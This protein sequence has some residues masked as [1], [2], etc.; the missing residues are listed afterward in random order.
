MSYVFFFSSRRRQTSCA[1][2]TEFR[3]VLF[4]SACRWR[5]GSADRPSCSGCASR[6]T[7]LAGAERNWRLGTW[8][9]SW[10]SGQTHQ[11]VEHLVDCLDQAGRGVVRVLADGHVGQLLVEIHA[12]FGL[13]SVLK[14]LEEEGLVVEIGRAHVCTPVPNTSL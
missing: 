6:R 7:W 10:A 11:G 12:G 1:L 9:F 2:V 8:C 14:V 4:R 3:L 13:E 5:S